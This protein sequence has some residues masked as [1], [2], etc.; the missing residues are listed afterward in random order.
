MKPYFLV[1]YNFLK[2]SWIRLIKCR[3][4]SFGK[5]QMFGYHTSCHFSSD[6]RI[7]FGNKIVSNGRMLIQ[8]EGSE[9][10]IGIMYILMMVW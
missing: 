8:T 5:I 4:L 2:F 3:K 7:V 10:T 9:L 1:G 6:S